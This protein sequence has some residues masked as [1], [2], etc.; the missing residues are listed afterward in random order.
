MCIVSMMHDHFRDRFVPWF[1]PNRLPWTDPFPGR[2]GPFPRVR[3]R[4]AAP[5]AKSL[6]EEIAD[7]LAALRPLISE[8]KEALVKARRLDELTKQPDC[9]SP[10]KATLEER[11]AE[12]ERKLEDMHRRALLAESVERLA[13]LQGD[14][15]A[16]GDVQP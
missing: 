15:S 10:E 11:V 16:G 9:E 2:I 4:P 1:D 8:Y 12:L 7:E 3:K 6:S 13:A 5:P 14:D